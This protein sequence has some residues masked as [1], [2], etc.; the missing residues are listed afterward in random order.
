MFKKLKIIIVTIIIFS[1]IANPVLANI[2]SV[3]DNVVAGAYVQSPGVY[4]SPSNTTLSMGSM[5]FRLKNDVLGKPLFGVTPPRANLSCAGMDFDAGMISMLNLDQFEGM[6]SQAGA[7]LAWGIMIGIVYSL[8]GIGDAFQKLQQW[9]REAQKLFQNS[10]NI[11]KAIG[12]SIGKQIFED[13]STEAA[14]K[15]TAEGLSSTFSQAMKKVGDYL[16]VFDLTQTFP[17]GALSKVGFNIDVQDLMASWFGY[18]DIY[19]KDQN[20]NKITDMSKAVKQA[21]PDGKYSSEQI[22][23][24]MGGPMLKSIDEVLHGGNIMIWKCIG[25]QGNFCTDVVSEE[26]ITEGLKKKMIATIKGIRD[27]LKNEI[28]SGAGIGD[29]EKSFWNTST[30]GASETAAVT[31]LMANVVPGFFDIMSYSAAFAKSMKTE[32]Q[33]LSESILEDSAELAAYLLLDKVVNLAYSLLGQSVFSDNSDIAK[34]IPRDVFEIYRA[35]MN[36][37]HDK[38]QRLISY[39]AGM[40]KIIEEYARKYTSLMQFAKSSIQNKIGPGAV[41]FS[42]R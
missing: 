17:W 1:I 38:L 37:S 9:A 40:L 30:G 3:L 5:S 14:E 13:K 27:N 11:G 6:L 35:N 20:G 18:I 41:A 15:G 25:Q 26:V 10:C 4:K 24:N 33:I 8:P 22:G 42:G 29:T 32:Y 31:T 19:I 21:A 36:E 39:K 7:S 34:N 12:S 16:K 23:F 28:I 2:D